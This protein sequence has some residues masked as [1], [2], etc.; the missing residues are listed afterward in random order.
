METGAALR[1]GDECC[2]NRVDAGTLVGKEGW[3]AGG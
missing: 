2:G 1:E 3:E